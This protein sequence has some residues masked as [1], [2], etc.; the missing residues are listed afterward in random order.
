MKFKL[1]IILL[2]SALTVGCVKNVEYK[3]TVLFENKSSYDIAFVSVVESWVDGQKVAVGAE[4]RYTIKVAESATV[5][6]NSRG[7]DISVGDIWLNKDIDY[8]RFGDGLKVDIAGGKYM[9]NAT[10][11]LF[12]SEADGE[13]YIYTFTD[14][15]YQYAVENGTT[16]E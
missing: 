16:L 8:I 15:D 13:V 9:D 14:E 11:T 4:D 2:F 6:T 5:T 12:S 3:V 10:Y 7:G 1:F